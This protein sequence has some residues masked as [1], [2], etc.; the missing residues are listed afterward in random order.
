[1]P[2]CLLASKYSMAVIEKALAM[3]KMDA[4]VITSTLRRP[5]EQAAAM[6]KNAAQNMAGQF[7]LYGLTGDEVLKVYQ[8]NKAKPRDAGDRS[9]GRRTIAALMGD[10]RI[11]SRHV[12]SAASYAKLNVI[13]VGLG[14]TPG[15]KR[16]PRSS[17][18]S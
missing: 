13:D 6:Y 14:S 7:A 11:V 3:A 5:A 18:A 2:S 8:A 10:G 17:W 4:A 16:A 1:M 12:V 9:Y 15:G